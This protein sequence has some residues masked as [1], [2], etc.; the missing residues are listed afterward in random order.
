MLTCIDNFLFSNE[1]FLPVLLFFLTIRFQMFQP[2]LSFWYFDAF[3][4][5][6]DQKNNKYQNKSLCDETADLIKYSIPSYFYTLWRFRN[7]IKR[8]LQ[9]FL[10][11]CRFHGRIGIGFGSPYHI[12][13]R[14]DNSF[15]MLTLQSHYIQAPIRLQVRCT[16]FPSQKRFPRE[17]SSAHFIGTLHRLLFAY[18]LI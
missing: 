18:F 5:I 17:T 9:V 7:I 10:F 11:F 13:F 1:R 8:L 6:P 12:S 16:Y 2:F 14:H 15:Y 3:Q 4:K